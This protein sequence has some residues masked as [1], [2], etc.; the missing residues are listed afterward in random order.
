MARVRTS[1]SERRAGRPGRRVAEGWLAFQQSSIWRYNETKKESRCTMGHRLW[2]KVW[3]QHKGSA[4][5]S[6]FI[7]NYASLLLAC[8]LTR[9]AVDRRRRWTRSTDG[10]TME[11]HGLFGPIPRLPAGLPE[12]A[13]PMLRAPSRCPLRA[14]RRA[15][16]R[17]SRTLS[18]SPEPG[19]HPSA[20]VG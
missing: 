9:G 19:G 8:L 2:E 16:Y 7:R 12:L 13:L 1:L 6:S 15:A 10:S 11:R 20:P 18:A 3:C 5:S 17:G 14:Y 4:P